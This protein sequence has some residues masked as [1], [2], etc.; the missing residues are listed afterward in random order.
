M[1]A[2]A[3]NIEIDGIGQI[4]FERSKRA[5]NINISL[6]PFKGVRIAVPYGVSFDKARQVAQSK[7]GWIRKHLDKIKQVEKAHDVFIKNSIEIDRAEAKKK[8]VYRLNELSEKHDFNY[9]KVFIRNQKTRWGSCSARN[10]ISLNMKLV[11]LPGEMIDY[12][13]LHELVHTRI[14]NHAN[15]FWA[16]LNRLDGDAKEKN[17]KMNEYK[18]FLL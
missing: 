10:N 7:R 1:K 14:K 2:K 4:F 13:L 9:N 18:M 16:E 6:K 11:R 3:E 15:G 17:K 5:K 8:L 12:V